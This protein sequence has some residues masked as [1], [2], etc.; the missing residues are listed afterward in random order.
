MQ[1]IV[2]AAAAAQPPPPPPAALKKVGH[3]ASILT[4]ALRHVFNKD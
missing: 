4:P 1:F 2:D 3:N